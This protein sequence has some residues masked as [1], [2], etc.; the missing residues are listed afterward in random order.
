MD[1]SLFG[2]GTLAGA[3]STFR[4]AGVF[5]VVLAVALGFPVGIAHASPPDTKTTTG[6]GA[7]LPTKEAAFGGEPWALL[8]EAVGACCLPTAIAGGS[9]QCVE[10]TECECLA[11]GGFWLPGQA[12]AAVVC[13]GACCLT[14]GTCLGGTGGNRANCAINGGYFRP[15][16]SCGGAVC[17]V[18]CCLPNG[19]CG[20]MTTPDCWAAGGWPLQPEL[21]CRSCER[22]SEFKA[23]CPSPSV[24]NDL[25]PI[26]DLQG[27]CTY[28]DEGMEAF[29]CDSR[30]VAQCAALGGYF[31]GFEPGLC[32]EVNSPAERY[33]VRYAREAF[34]ALEGPFNS[35]VFPRFDASDPF[36]PLT[37]VI[38]KVDGRVS[39]D[40]VLRSQSGRPQ[41]VTVSQLDVNLRYEIEDLFG[42]PDSVRFLVAALAIP[43]LF[44]PDVDGPLEPNACVIIQPDGRPTV[45]LRPGVPDL[46]E[47]V[48]A[49]GLPFEFFQTGNPDLPP[50]DPL[51]VFAHRG[52]GNFSQVGGT[53]AVFNRYPNLACGTVEVIYEF[54]ILG[55]CCFC[56]DNFDPSVPSTFVFCEDGLTLEECQAIGGSSY[57]W[58]PSA[59]CEDVQNM[60]G[61]DCYLGSC[62]IYDTVLDTIEC[63]TGIPEICCLDIALNDPNK[64]V[65]WAEPEENDCE[66]LVT[67]CIQMD[68]FFEKCIEIEVRCYET[69]PFCCSWLVNIVGGVAYEAVEVGSCD[70]KGICCIPYSDTEGATAY[71]VSE[72][73]C[74]ALFGEFNPIFYAVDPDEE[75][76][77]DR[78]LTPP[79]CDCDP[80]PPGCLI[81]TGKG[82]LVIFSKIEV[83]WD[84][85]GNLLQDTF[86]SLTN[87]WIHPVRI[88]MYFVN[89]DE[90]LDAT[91]DERAHPG[92]NTVR[93]VFTLTQ[94]Q[95]IAWSAVSGRPYNFPSW[96]ALDPGTPPGRPAMDGTNER[97]L[98]GFIYAW[99]VEQ[100]VEEDEGN[101]EVLVEE[102]QIRWN[103][104]S[105]SATLVY[106]TNGV[107]AWEYPACAAAVKADV[108]HGSTFGTPGILRLNGL[109]YCQAP[110]DLLLNFLAVGSEAFSNQSL[111]LT[112]DTDVTL[113]PVSVDLRPD[114]P[115][116]PDRPITTFARYQIWN[117]NE[118]KFSSGRC[119]TCWD[120]SFLS[121]YDD[122]FF[123]EIFDRTM[124]GTDAGKARIRGVGSPLCNT[125]DTT[126]RRAG[127]IGLYARHFY[128]AF[129]P[130][131]PVSE[132]TYHDAAGGPLIGMGGINAEIR[133]ALPGEPQEAPAYFAYPVQPLAR[134]DAP[135]NQ[136][137]AE[138]EQMLKRAAQTT[139]D[140]GQ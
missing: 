26:C 41:N 73:C 127:L 33:V 104:L 81:C 1:C 58:T 69:S 116:S 36:R 40:V 31:L 76:C 136:V 52:Q 134:P 84:A 63:I 137:D 132:R 16:E 43:P 110:A 56:P 10:I 6:S 96:T 118:N 126:S 45:D 131:F 112:A 64:R 99:A 4:R 138:I 115:P 103:H 48:E 80:P 21:F 119:L 47:Y 77:D 82:S 98:R 54:D 97:V 122:I 123:I 105:G 117:E 35:V 27:S 91:P 78:S 29:V 113:H 49:D 9:A 106:Y 67:C 61:S 101:G 14:D 121:M 72:A 8:G 60:P 70:P 130:P 74:E 37:R 109:E 65:V 62:C 34:S 92:W 128:T 17:H 15:L 108:P 19:T 120:Q 79:P 11:T 135:F 125:E 57:V 39:T 83:R 28:F 12:C 44:E 87:D 32:A 3:R 124:L 46:F 24:P 53:N 38:L 55:A 59:T 66:E 107:Y 88:V 102:R 94:N 2:S 93:H 100:V 140:E 30:T 68:D 42:P 13:Y 95:P 85:D 18:P 89:G 129:N 133:W 139:E 7:P 86:V 71:C 111:T 50:R 5:I 25:C 75:T 20:F 51:A 90:P 22:L 114:L 23:D